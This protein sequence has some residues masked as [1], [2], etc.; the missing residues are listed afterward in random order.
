MASSEI[1]FRGKSRHLKDS[2]L[3][4]FLDLIEEEINTSSLALDKIDW[5][6][7]ACET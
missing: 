1:I 6:N 2:A 4:R 7:K 3:G 5:L